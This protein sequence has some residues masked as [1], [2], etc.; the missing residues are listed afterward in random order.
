MTEI[1]ITSENGN[2]VAEVN[3]EKTYELED[4]IHDLGL[5]FGETLEIGYDMDN[6]NDVWG[7]IDAIYGQEG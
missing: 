2:L 4:A 6:E 7:L 3:G 5:G 1:H